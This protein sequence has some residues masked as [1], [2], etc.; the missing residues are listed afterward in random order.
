MLVHRLEAKMVS[1]NQNARLFDHQ[2][3][4]KESIILNFLHGGSHWRRLAT[5]TTTFGW[6]LPGVPSHAQTYLDL[7]QTCPG[8]YNQ[9]TSS[10]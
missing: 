9:V 2:Y 4:W 1:S 8:G 3:L 5:E 6:E 10:S 7:L